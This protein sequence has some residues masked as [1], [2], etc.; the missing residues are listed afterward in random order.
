[1]GLTGVTRVM[2]VMEKE[3]EEKENENK[4]LRADGPIN[5]TRGPRGPKKTKRKNNWIQVLNYLDPGPRSQSL[6]E[7]TPKNDQE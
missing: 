7:E 3:E 1:M 5:S 4:F 2:R 6:V